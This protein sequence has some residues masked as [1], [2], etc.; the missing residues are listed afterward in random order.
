MIC[1][2]SHHWY[3]GIQGTQNFGILSREF[4]TQALPTEKQNR[5]IILD[6]KLTILEKRFVISITYWKDIKE[7][8]IK[9]FNNCHTVM[10][11]NVLGSVWNQN[12][13]SI[14][15]FVK[16]FSSSPCS[17]KTGGIT[18]MTRLMKTLYVKEVNTTELKMKILHSMNGVTIFY[19]LITS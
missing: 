7:A 1:F 13:E 4:R 16:A 18:D 8:F 14:P 2:S 15:G 17:F 5:W 12:N 19:Y 11:K 3:P 10:S 6:Y 9:M